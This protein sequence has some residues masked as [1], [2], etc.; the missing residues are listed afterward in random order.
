M[1]K[2]TIKTVVIAVTGITIGLGIT[3]VSFADT[4]L[5]EFEQAY[6][7]TAQE[8]QVAQYN[9]CRAE[10]E[11]A[12][13]KLN[14]YSSNELEL[15]LNALNRITTKTKNKCEV[16]ESIIPLEEQKEAVDSMNQVKVVE[17]DQFDLDCWA[18]AVATAE[19]G[20]CTTGMG[21]TKNNCFGIMTWENGYREGK[22]YN[23]KE[24]S[25]V[26]FK[27]LWKTKYNNS[28]PTLQTIKTYTGN[29]NPLTW[30]KNTMA[31]YNACINKLI[32]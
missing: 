9:H 1:K 8:L 7:D 15:D 30:Q 18:K 25:Y 21:I 22:T 24:E 26:D 27:E 29:D 14:M 12:N 16:P 19:T 20:D 3:L 31:T 23:S 2:Q 4:S 32:K 10:L 13:K 6:R 17:I 5:F 28:L 11:L